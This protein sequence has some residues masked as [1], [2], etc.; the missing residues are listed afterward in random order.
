MAAGR[1]HSMFKDE[2]FGVP[3]MIERSK[4][5]QKNGVRV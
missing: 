3:T 5:K 1:L 2:P 4:V